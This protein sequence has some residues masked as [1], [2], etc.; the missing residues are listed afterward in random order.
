MS[1]GWHEADHPRDAE[2]QFTEK[3]TGRLIDRLRPQRR[4]TGVDRVREL[5]QELAAEIPGEI[6]GKLYSWSRGDGLLR[7]IIERQGFDGPPEVVSRADMD[8]MVAT[9]EVIETWRG[10]T[11]TAVGA[12]GNYQHMSAAEMA[13]AYRTGDF[14][15]GQGNYGNGTYVAIDRDYAEGLLRR[16]DAGGLLRIGLRSDARIIDYKDIEPISMA[17][18]DDR[19]DWVDGARGGRNLSPAEMVELAPNYLWVDDGRLAA[20][21]GYDAIKVRRS[22]GAFYIILNRTATVVQEAEL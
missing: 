3:W 22:S 18:D 19:V 2:G 16:N 12:M 8:R 17:Y 7:R 20:A 5:E 14:Y 11:G 1:R 10:L 21:M 6:A 13:E 4:A 9:G 15:V